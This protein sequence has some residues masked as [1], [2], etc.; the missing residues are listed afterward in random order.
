MLRL[1]FRS[2][3]PRLPLL[4]TAVSLVWCGLWIGSLGMDVS[5]GQAVDLVLPELAYWNAWALLT[6]VIVWLAHRYANESRRLAWRWALHLPLGM[7]VAAVAFGVGAALFAVASTMLE[8]MGLPQSLTVGERLAGRSATMVSFWLPFG[9]LVYVLL[10]GVGLTQGYLQRLRAEERQS[11]AL[12]AQLAEARLDVLARQLHPHFLFNALNTISAT[13]HEDPE[14]ADRM[15]S[16]LGD[17]LRCTLDQADRPVVPLRDDLA[18][19]EQYLRIVQDRFE[20]RL[21][22]R[23]DVA[24]SVADAAV[25]YLLLQ[26]LVENAVRHGV[27]LHAGPARVEVRGH[28]DDEAVVL[29][30]FNSAPEGARH[31][32]LVG[33]EGGLGLANTRARLAA[34]FA[35]ASLPGDSGV[36]P[37]VVLTR[38]AGGVVARLHFPYRPISRET[39]ST[40]LVPADG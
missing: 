37:S 20:D 25:P 7:L 24:P 32:A 19:G 15:L 6:P 33:A 22:V 3:W 35:P 14:T 31:G 11:A 30:V 13:L 27:A 4:Y 28:R 2:Y 12:R 8:A 18:F 29:E 10:V 26:P 39:T 9:F 17:F 40:A 34:T 23:F 5:L 36:Q 21:V 1:Y 16:R 38:V